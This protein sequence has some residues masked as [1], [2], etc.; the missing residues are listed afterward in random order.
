MY[1]KEYRINVSL[2][3]KFSFSSPPRR[4]GIFEYRERIFIAYCLPTI[5][6]TEVYF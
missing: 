5:Q 6:Q 1:L 4:G 3:I 2:N